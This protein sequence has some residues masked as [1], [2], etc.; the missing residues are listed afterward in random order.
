LQHLKSSAK[1][2]SYTKNS[3]MLAN[4]HKTRIVAET[5]YWFSQQNRFFN[6][7]VNLTF[8]EMI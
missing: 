3:R 4:M 7:C 2:V 1:K 5:L 8:G 6:N